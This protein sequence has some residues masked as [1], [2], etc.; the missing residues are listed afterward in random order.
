MLLSLVL[1]IP[2]V[3]MVIIGYLIAQAPELNDVVAE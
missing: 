1:I 3:S 2:F